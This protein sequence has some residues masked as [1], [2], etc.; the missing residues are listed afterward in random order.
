MIAFS[1]FLLGVFIG[2]FFLHLYN[3]E[4]EDGSRNEGLHRQDHHENDG[5]G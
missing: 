3:E 2:A 4:Y 5:R 1:T